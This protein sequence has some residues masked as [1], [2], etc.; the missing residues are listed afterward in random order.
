MF[1]VAER[2]GNWHL[3]LV[4]IE[5]MINLF[6]ATGHLHYAKSSR[7]YLQLM[8]DL[9]NDFPWLYKEFTKHGFHTVRRSERPCLGCGLIW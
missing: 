4:T 5:Q 9:K 3:Y 8:M 7:L 6:A 1:I 2:T